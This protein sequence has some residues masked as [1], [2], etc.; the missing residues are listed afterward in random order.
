MTILLHVARG[1]V[2]FFGA[3]GFLFGQVFC[4]NYSIPA[5]LA[6]VAGV[7]TGLISWLPS[8]SLV[9]RAIVT[10]CGV[11]GVVGV[12]MDALHYYT[13]LHSPGNYYAWFLIGPF[14]AFLLLIGC[15]TWNRS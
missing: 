8:R 11:A 13:T 10:L 4:G 9:V 2:V 14:T 15:A 6:G 7:L 1:Y 5:T 3:A 12:T